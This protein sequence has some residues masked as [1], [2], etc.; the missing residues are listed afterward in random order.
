[1]SPLQ[2]AS[3]ASLRVSKHHISAYQNFPNTSL[4]P[5]PFMI[6]HSAY[7][8]S[9]LS[10]SSVEQHLRSIG[11]VNPA[12]RYTMYKQHHYHS[13]VDE[14]LVVVKGSAKLCFGGSL[15]NPDK[16][17]VEVSK[18][19]AMIVPAGVGHALLEDKSEDEPFQMVGSYPIGSKNW[20]M[21]TGEDSDKGSKWKTIRT[22]G[23]LRG[24][25]IYGDKG[26]VLDVGE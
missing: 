16:L 22:L 3:L 9:S 23:W 5:Y 24:D 7:S 4:R 20:D 15:S 26:P 14:V 6:Y 21:C 1:M 19:D 8:P 12:W 17:E 25:P 2:P 18:G 10:A 11:V 13:N